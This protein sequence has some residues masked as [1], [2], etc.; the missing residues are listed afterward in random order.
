MH[1]RFSCRRSALRTRQNTSMQTGQ[2]IDIAPTPTTSKVRSL[3]IYWCGHVIT[4]ISSFTTMTVFIY[5]RNCFVLTIILLVV[6][7]PVFTTIEKTRYRKQKVIKKINKN[8]DAHDERYDCFCSSFSV[9]SSLSGRK[10]NRNQTSPGSLRHDR[11]Q[12]HF[13]MKYDNT[14]KQL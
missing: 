13:K 8:I 3:L 2:S 10:P 7:K 9:F 4:F 14:I 1:S 6:S 12:G 5:G 11:I